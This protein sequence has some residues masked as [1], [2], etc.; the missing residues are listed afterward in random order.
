MVMIGF[1]FFKFLV[2]NILS[3]PRYYIHP[4]GLIPELDKFVNSEE[5]RQ[6]P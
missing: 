5:A 1:W 6:F 2:P 4:T 3:L